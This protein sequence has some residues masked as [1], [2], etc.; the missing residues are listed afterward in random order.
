MELIDK[1]LSKEE[2]LYILTK[3]VSVGDI[4]LFPARNI[5]I[6]PVTGGTMFAKRGIGNNSMISINSEDDGNF[7]CEFVGGKPLPKFYVRRT[8]LE[9]RGFDEIFF[10]EWFWGLPKAIFRLI[11]SKIR[12]IK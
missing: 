7:L 1:W 8:D 10:L 2:R 3:K 4:I 12:M 5:E 9:I 6:K 11:A